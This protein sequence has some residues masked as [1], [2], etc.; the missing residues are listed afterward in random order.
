VSG[1]I[2]FTIE[3]WLKALMYVCEAKFIAAGAWLC[4]GIFMVDVLDTVF[5]AATWTDLVE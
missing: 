5:N 1:I 2:V 3:A 4:V